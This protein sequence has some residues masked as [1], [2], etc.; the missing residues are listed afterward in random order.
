MNDGEKFKESD[1]RADDRD[2]T[3]CIRRVEWA[4][5]NR[6]FNHGNKKEDDKVLIETGWQMWW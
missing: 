1:S 5:M 2:G 6:Q 4:K 3:Q